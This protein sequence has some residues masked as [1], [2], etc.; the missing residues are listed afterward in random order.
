MENIDA[1]PYANRLFSPRLAYKPEIED[2]SVVIERDGIPLLL[3]TEVLPTD[4]LLD[5]LNALDGKRTLDEIK[6]DFPPITCEELAEFVETLDRNALID[7]TDAYQFKSGVEALFELEDTLNEL[8]HDKLYQNVFWKNCQQERVTIPK[9]ILY[10]LAIEH[11]HFLFRQNYFDAPILA[12]R[13]TGEIRELMLDFFHDEYRHD[14]IILKALNAIGIS[15][16][17]LVD[18]M[19]L[20]TTL[21]LCNALTYW[22]NNDPLFFFLTLSVLEGK[23]LAKDTYVD[24]CKKVGLDQA[25]IKPIES[26]ANINLKHQHGN[27][28]RL[29]FKNIP[30]VD[31]F[32]LRRLKS[33]LHLFVA[34]YDNF[35]TEVWQ[36]YTDA[37]KLLRRVSD[38]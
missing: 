28:T 7:V 11:Y 32:N 36:H 1:V 22:S 9:N 29:I 6:Q 33:T 5:L 14:T 16:E 20:P 19:P 23:D 2:G 27:L 10:G 13:N 15:E 21:S 37:P 4:K 12:R 24:I 18:T 30:H 8:L 38:I 25:F 26:H 17:D 35:Y 34:M 31:A 3:E